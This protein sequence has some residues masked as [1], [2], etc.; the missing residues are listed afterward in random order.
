MKQRLQRSLVLLLFLLMS[1]GGV[2]QQ[3]PHYGQYMF[4][5]YYNNPA[6]AG[7]EDISFASLAYR[8]QWSGLQGAPRTGVA[9]FH[10]DLKE[11]VGLGGML[12]SD[13]NGHFRRS[14]LRL[15][16]AYHFDLSDRTRLGFGLAGVLYQHSLDRAAL[17]PKVDGDPALEGGEG[18]SWDPD[19]T[20]GA[21]LKGEQY[22]VSLSVSHLIGSEILGDRLGGSELARHFDLGAGYLFDMG[23]KWGLEPSFMM[24]RTIA[25]PLNIDINGK[26][27]YDELI[28]VGAS[29]RTS[30][31][32]LAMLGVQKGQFRLGYSY[33]LGTSAIRRYSNGSH[34]I[35]LGMRIPSGKDPALPSF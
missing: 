29:Y 1:M 25:S 11:S 28:W 34:E 20:F 27:I 14:G 35:H 30:G 21:F 8:A 2:A 19:G 32:V 13:K 33:D 3:L 18:R 9:A 17:N 23:D 4:N 7:S 10:T 22:H 6:V 16:Y 26:L 31:S 24:R 5:R 15:S 12:F